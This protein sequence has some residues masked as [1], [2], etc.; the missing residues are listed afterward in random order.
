M[1]E[2]AVRVGAGL[3]QRLRSGVQSQKLREHRA[4]FLPGRSPNPEPLL[5]APGLPMTPLLF[6]SRPTDTKMT[7]PAW[8]PMPMWRRSS[9]AACW[10]TTL[11]FRKELP[12]IRLARAYSQ[13]REAGSKRRSASEMAAPYSRRVAHHYEALP[14]LM[15]ESEKGS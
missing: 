12:T 8:D 11:A 1:E 3:M 9:T 4:R 7:A 14:M 15:A 6:P 10:R 13:L 2:A 5:A